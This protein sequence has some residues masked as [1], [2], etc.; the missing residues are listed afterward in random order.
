[1]AATKIESTICT[2]RNE[3]YNSV[4]MLRLSCAHG[5]VSHSLD[6][7]SIKNYGTINAEF[8]YMQES[9]STLH[10]E[11]CVAH[12]NAHHF[13]VSKCTAHDE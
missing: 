13:K 5:F 3:L 7:Q 9:E 4:R 12:L 1:M 2:F 8:A 6:E 11:I 10:L